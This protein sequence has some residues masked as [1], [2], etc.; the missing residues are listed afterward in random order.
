MN[1]AEYINSLIA[2]GR[3]SFSLSEATEQL[4]ISRRAAF[5][6]IKRLKAKNMIANPAKGFYVIVTPEYQIYECLPAEFF[7][8][9][10]MKFWKTD[11]YAGLLTAAMFHGASH[12]QPQAF[13][14]I[15]NK[16][17]ATINCGKIK[18]EFVVKKNIQ[19][20]PLQTVTTAKNIL[21][22][23]TPEITAMD[24]LLY[25]NRCGGLN[26]VATILAE[27]HE[28]ISPEKLSELLESQP[29]LAWKQRLGYL[30]TLLDTPELAKVVKNYLNKQKRVDYIPLMP[31]VS[32]QEEHTK[33]KEWKIIENAE[34]ESDI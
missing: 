16:K 26:H 14:V 33:N 28:K 23:S 30:L 27:L 6:A 13:Q 18:I 25:T 31:E 21:S 4:G 24:L 19:S 5:F 34:I 9:D 29:E 8:S 10:L 20:I 12:Q 22:I 32:I 7:I 15:T 1:A 11:Y 2:H 17:R 3:Y